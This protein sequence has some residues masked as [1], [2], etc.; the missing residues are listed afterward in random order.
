MSGARS[1][2]RAPRRRSSRR[3]FSRCWSRSG[4]L[5]S[6]PTSTPSPPRARDPT[7]GCSA[8]CGASSIFSSSRGRGAALRTRSGSLRTT[9][10]RIPT[11]TPS[12]SC[13][14][15]C[16]W[17][18]AQVGVE[19][20]HLQRQ[21]RDRHPRAAGRLPW[22]PVGAPFRQLR[23]TAEEMGQ[24]ASVG[25]GPCACTLPHLL[26][27]DF[28]L[29]NPLGPRVGP[30]VVPPVAPPMPGSAR[31]EREETPGRRLRPPARR[32]RPGLAGAVAPASGRRPRGARRRRRGAGV[33][34]E[35]P[36]RGSPALPGLIIDT[37]LARAAH[38]VCR[39][40][41]RRT[42]TPVPQQPPRSRHAE[43]EVPK[44]PLNHPDHITALIEEGKEAMI[45]RQMKIMMKAIKDDIEG[46]VMAALGQAAEVAP[47]PRRR[48]GGDRQRR[49]EDRHRHHREGEGRPGAA[50][51]ASRPAAPRAR[52]SRCP[53]WPPSLHP[54]S[55]PG[56]GERRAAPVHPA[57]CDP[58]AAPA[59]GLHPAED[60]AEPWR[61]PA[62]HR[63]GPDD[64]RPSR[65][66]RPA[67]PCP[68]A[69]V[70]EPSASP[71]GAKRRPS[72]CVGAVSCHRQIAP[73]LPTCPASR[74]AP[75]GA[76]AGLAVHLRSR[77]D[78]RAAPGDVEAGLPARRLEDTPSTS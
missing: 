11:F 55:S 30:L 29:S 8:T 64:R 42:A 27:V 57:Q 35:S 33:G 15:G 54:R 69:G 45:K 71:A 26:P 21:A 75:R 68:C 52:W 47:D 72:R 25:G 76:K 50:R 66:R 44:K 73:S 40:L 59:P 38:H 49:G 65:L 77:H 37:Y 74:R 18:R 31:R 17:R 1:A 56:R 7:S 34:Q 32:R 63:A 53:F 28:S 20:R 9:G 22:H 78:R 3:P 23:G 43:A 16:P 4:S 13:R 5:A 19:G 2:S 62:V 48:R 10:E 67:L 39:I 60:R 41:I 58:R 70:D 46:G 6:A 12:R 24:E 61:A 51:G 36:H 14:P